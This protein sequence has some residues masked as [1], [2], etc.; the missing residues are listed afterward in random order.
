MPL[1]KVCQSLD[2]LYNIA[3]AYLT[4][5]DIEKAFGYFLRFVDAVVEQL[6]KHPNY[7]SITPE[8]NDKLCRR[9]IHAISTA[10]KLKTEIFKSY[11]S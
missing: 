3:M 5:K 7:S 11:C 6:P 10:E 9:T 8:Y 2:S 1:I 4:E